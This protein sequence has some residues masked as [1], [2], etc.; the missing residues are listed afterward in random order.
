[1]KLAILIFILLFSKGVYAQ[2]D[3]F[4]SMVL[5]PSGD[6]IMGKNTKPGGDFSP[7][8]KISVDSFYM[9]LHEV[10]NGEYLEFCNQTAHKLPEFWN[11]D[12]FRCGDNYLEYPVVG[13]NWYDARTY[14]KWAGKRLPTEAEWEYAARGGLE[15]NEFPNGNEWSIP[16]R[17]NDSIGHWENLIVKVASFKPNGFGLY[18][19]GG[20]VWEWVN[21]IYQHNYYRTS[22][23]INPKG[24][25]NGTNRVIRGGSW[26]SGKMCHKVYYRKGLTTNWVDFAVGFRCVKDISKQ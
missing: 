19:M 3:S 1:M 7:A 9:D 12:I 18:D 5:I 17:R 23:I 20:N 6:F 10:T 22:P 8:H 2:S 11:V 24:P 26:H 4:D 13:I 14:A 15:N 25:E 16:I 21:D